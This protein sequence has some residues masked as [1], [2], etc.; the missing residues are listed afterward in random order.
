MK[1]VEC[2]HA[3]V[4]YNANNACHTWAKAKKHWIKKSYYVICINKAVSTVYVVNSPEI[5]RELSG[6]PL[7]IN[8]WRV[9]TSKNTSRMIRQILFFDYIFY[10]WFL[11]NFLHSTKKHYHL[12]III[13]IHWLKIKCH[14]FK[15]T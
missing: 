2:R 12:K 7:S 9:S 4:G 3:A 15:P 6:A 11:R 10:K 14:F 8:F 1:E 5:F 13:Y